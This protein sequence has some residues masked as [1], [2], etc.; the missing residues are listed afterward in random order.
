MHPI[1]FE[2]GQQVRVVRTIRND[3][4]FPG[5]SRGELLVRQGS[6]GYIK[7][8]GTFLQDQ[9]IYSVDFV[10][11][12]CL[13]GCREH[14]I[15]L[16]SDPWIQTRFEFHQKVTPVRRLGIEGVVIAEPG[17]EGEIE[18][19]LR[20]LPGGPA[21]H[22]RFAGRILQVSESSLLPLDDAEEADY[23]SAL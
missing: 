2:Y 15:Q 5:K 14:E 17:M 6:V 16:A 10:D 7:D 23:A 4:T 13:V 3:G 20:D 12:N 11:S 1:R 8:V 19:V 9:V 22:V 21:Y 18:K